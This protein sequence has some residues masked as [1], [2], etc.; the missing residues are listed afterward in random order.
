LGVENSVLFNDMGVLY[1]AIDLNN[2]AEQYYL[3][4][5]QSD[6]NYLPAYMNLAYLYQRLGRK[7]KAAWYFQKRCELG[8]PADP[9]AQKAK[10]E[11]LVI[12]P[13]YLEWIQSLEA[14]SLNKQLVAQSRDEFYQQVKLGQEHYMKGENLFKQGKYKE[15]MKEYDLALNFTPENPKISD[16]RKKVILAMAKESVKENSEQ[17]I[18][19]LEMGDTVSAR[20]EIE[21]ILT[22]IPKE[23]ILTSW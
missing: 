4:A 16:A 2:R 15:A 21:K 19:R 20:H 6:A 17:A 23:P 22:T 8:D 7:E 18:K 11:L 9:W 13:E 14:D 1:E 3:K 5:I 12:K 10:E